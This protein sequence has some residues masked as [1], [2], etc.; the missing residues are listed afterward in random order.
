MKGV[1]SMNVKLDFASFS[2]V[3][4]FILTVGFYSTGVNAQTL[5]STNVIGGGEVKPTF[6]VHKNSI[7]QIGIPHATSTKVTWETEEWDSNNNFDLALDRFTQTVA[8]KYHFIAQLA[9]I[10]PTDTSQY[11]VRIYKNGD[12][13]K[14][15]FIYLASKQAFSIDVSAI[16]EAN[17]VTDYFEVYSYHTTGADRIVYGIPTHTFFQGYKVTE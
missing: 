4:I 10:K 7:N 11:R 15:R 14:E 5:Q 13:A 3:A 6:L 2:T 8:G 9:Y 16:L 1:H 17:G 12:V